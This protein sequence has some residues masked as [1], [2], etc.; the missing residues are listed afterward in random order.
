MVRGVPGQVPGG[1]RGQDAVDDLGRFESF[2]RQGPGGRAANTR[3]FRSRSAAGIANILAEDARIKLYFAKP[4]SLTQIL[5]FFHN[6]G[7][8][9]LDQRPFEI[10]R[11][12]GQEFFLYDLGLKYPAGVDPAE[13]SGLLADSFRA[14]MRG[15]IESDSF[16]GLVLT[17]RIDWQRVVILRSYAKYLLQLGTTNSYGFM[18]DALLANV[19]VT[20]ALLGLF[21]TSFDPGITGTDRVQGIEA[22]GKELAAAIDEV[23]TLDADRLLRTFMNLI[24]ATL[25]TNYFLH[26][27]YLS[28]KFNPSVIAACPFPRPKY[29]IWV[30]SPAGGGGAP[31]LRGHRPRRTAL[32]GPEGGFPHGDPWPG[33]GPNGQE[34]RHRAHRGQGRLL[35][36][37]AAHPVARP[38]CVAGGGA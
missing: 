18:A 8:E 27:P 15:D 24:G 21:E 1:L 19:R 30:Y 14:A 3:R 23:P 33:Q 35:S 17:E 7:L 2:D 22:A 29:E 38:R 36:Q 16:D 25:R 37:A 4:R 6:L 10:R 9:V 31:A 5:P 11:G 26:R 32:V 34:R 20:H 28:Y 12:D 13:T